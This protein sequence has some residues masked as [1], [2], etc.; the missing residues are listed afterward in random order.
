M[1][2]PVA[3]SFLG[4]ERIEKSEE[5]RYA[6]CGGIVSIGAAQQHTTTLH[7]SFFTFLSYLM[8]N[9]FFPFSMVSRAIS[10]VVMPLS[11]ASFSAI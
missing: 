5:L 3:V 4:E 6:A 10:S 2:R 8:S 7:S 9:N 11:W 1:R